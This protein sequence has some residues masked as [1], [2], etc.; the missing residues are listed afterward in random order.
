[1]SQSE[2]RAFSSST[3]FDG[4]QSRMVP[5][6]FTDAN[7]SS[8]SNNKN[9][10]SFVGGSGSMPAT[11]SPFGNNTTAGSLSPFV[12]SASNDK[13]PFSSA[14]NNT[15]AFNSD[16][17]GTSM[18]FGPS[19]S[20][21][22]QKPFELPSHSTTNPLGA[23]TTPS[24]VFGKPSLS[25]KTTF[26]SVSTT[27]FASNTTNSNQSPFGSSTTTSSSTPTFG[28]KTTREI[29]VAFYQKYNPA[30]VVEVDKLLN[31]YAGKEEQL[32]RNLA[33]RYNL[34]PSFF[35]LPEKISATN[36]SGFGVS[37]NFGT[38]FGT[39][40][41]LNGGSASSGGF[42]VTN[43]SPFVSTPNSTG[44][45]SGFGKPSG[46][47]NNA[48]AFGSPSGTTGFGSSIG[49]SSFG[50]GISATSGFGSLSSNNPGPSPAFG[51]NNTFASKASF[52]EG[53]GGFGPS[54]NNMSTFGSSTPVSSTPFGA[55][56]R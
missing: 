52:G 10:L 53:S 25:N 9:E 49:K 55:A 13:S 22:T 40:T 30:K 11:S 5:S 24:S 34:E 51:S 2:Q 17:V 20:S 47:G 43:A 21:T 28:G 29:L 18:P 54:S 8:E 23:A 44:G 39:S 50:A 7:E 42:G 46:L 45:V 12:A 4:E 31:K 38:T 36:A 19:S 26:G 37:T 35:G 6:T 32:L 1:M 56:R 14:S 41:Q 27:S 15:P 33:K 48:P 3:T 16:S